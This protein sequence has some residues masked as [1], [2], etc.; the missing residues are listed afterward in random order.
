MAEKLVSLFPSPGFCDEVMHFFLLTGL[1]DRRPGEP[2]AHQ[3]PDEVLNVKEFSVEDVRRMVKT[4]EIK[5]MK[6]ALGL[7]L[8]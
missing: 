3:D 7:T 8:L 1:R 5:D 6:T 2:A 4:G